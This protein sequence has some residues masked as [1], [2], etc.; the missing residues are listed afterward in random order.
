MLLPINLQ[1]RP[2]VQYVL[3]TRLNNMTERIISSDGQMLVSMQSKTSRQ[4]VEGKDIILKL[5]GISL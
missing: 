4:T 2:N 1:N 5:K 3:P